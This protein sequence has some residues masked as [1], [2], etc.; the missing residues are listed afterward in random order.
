MI[1]RS[2]RGEAVGEQRVDVVVVGGGPAGSTAGS[3]IRKYN[4][5]I[6]VLI[7]EKEKFPRE[8]VGESQLPPIGPILNEM[9]VWDKVEAANF[10]IK[11]GATYRW[12]SSPDLWD[13]EF[14]PLDK[15][16]D[17]PRP[18]K[19]AGQRLFTAFQVERARYDQI[20]LDH[21]AELG[22]E[23]REGTQV[24]GVDHEGGRINS[25]STNAGD[26][27]RAKHYLDCSGY[28]GVLRRGLGVGVEVP[29]QLKNMAVWD[30]WSNADWAVEIGVG[31]TR[32]Q[33]LSIASG[34][35]WFIPLGPTR[36]S[37]GYIC[38]VEHY[39]KTGLTPAELYDQALKQE[40]RVQELCKNAAPDGMVR[41]TKDWSF[42]AD[43]IVGENWFLVGESAGF[44]D[45]VLAGGLTLTHSAAR[46]VAYIILAEHEGF[47]EMKWLKRSH[48]TTQVNRIKQYIRFADFWYASNGQFTDLEEHTKDIAKSAGL[49][50]DPKEAFR[51]LSLGGFSDEDFFLPGLGGLDLLAVKEIA[52]RFTKDDEVRWE[53]SQYNIFKLNLTGAKKET[54]PVYNNGKVHKVEAYRRGHRMIP[55][56]GYYAKV[57]DVLQKYSDIHEIN[58]AFE[59]ITRRSENTPGAELT[60]QQCYAT[61]ETMLL[62]NWVSA[63][64]DPKKGVIKINM[65]GSDLGGFHDSTHELRAKIS[66]GRERAVNEGS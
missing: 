22:C 30:Y 2:K 66:E 46:E 5:D 17:E 61:L 19:F 34:W 37:I 41:T 14:L 29:T 40:P 15:F 25:I 48:E 16:H 33:V 53:L 20:L 42:I 10:P 59:M 13:F 24:T 58:K 43:K 56:V 12:G 64:R 23:V 3:L 35:I 57:M 27:I 60:V 44:A 49:K 9:G 38:P 36:T 52:R 54:I 63:K 4:P 7:L 65:G 51:W 11:V 18:A 39:K 32:V 47:G 50:M 28:T 45:P 62:D 1:C 31:G 26:T 21:A 8:H 6:S 55:R